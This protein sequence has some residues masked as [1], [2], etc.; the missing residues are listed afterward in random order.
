MGRDWVW[1]FFINFSW[2]G[3]S[4]NVVFL[5][6]V[7]VHLL[8]L[9]VSEIN[10]VPNNPVVRSLSGQLTI[11]ILINPNHLNMCVHVC[12][13]LFCWSASVVEMFITNNIWHSVWVTQHWLNHCFIVRVSSVHDYFVFS[14]FWF[15]IKCTKN[16]RNSMNNTSVFTLAEWLWNHPSEIPYIVV[17]VDFKIHF[18]TT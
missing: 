12:V 11:E 3:T 8:L 15:L 4:L 18:A 7:V 17:D 9:G 13:E 5:S 6:F 1:I 2:F 16:I 14:Y 10:V